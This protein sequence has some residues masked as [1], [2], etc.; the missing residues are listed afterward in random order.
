[1]QEVEEWFNNLIVRGD[2]ES[3]VDY[4]ER[5]K[6]SFKSKLVESFRNGKKSLAS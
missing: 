6:K 4:W 5:L 1:M 3:D 2:L